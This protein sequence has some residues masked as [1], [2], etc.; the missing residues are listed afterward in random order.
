MNIRIF[1]RNI[2][3]Y[4]TEREIQAIVQEHHYC[5]LFVVREE[6]FDLKVSGHIYVQHTH[7]ATQLLALV[8]SKQIGVTIPLSTLLLFLSV[9]VSPVRISL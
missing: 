7:V 9:S 5:R 6:H 2:R 4:F 3:L 1:N 8:Y